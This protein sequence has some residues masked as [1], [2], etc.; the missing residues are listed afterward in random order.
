M[1]SS[2]LYELR[3]FDEILFGAAGHP[4]VPDYRS[5]AE[6]IQVIR[7]GFH[8]YVNLRPIR[9]LPGVSPR[10]GLADSGTVD[11]VIVRENTEGEFADIGGRLHQ[12]TD[13]ELVVQSAVF[14]RR[15][16]ERIARFAFELARGRR[17]LVSNV[18]KSN[19]LRHGLVYWDEV[20]ASVACAYPDVRSDRLYVDA[21]TVAILY[22]PTSFDVIVTTNLL[23]DI[24]SDL[25]SVVVGGLGVCASGNLDPARQYPSMFEPIHGS[26]PDIAGRGIANPIG[27]IRSAGMLLDHLGESGAANR[28]EAALTRVA[29]DGVLTADVGGRSST[30]EVGAAVV[31]AIA[32]GG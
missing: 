15:G 28:I 10:V 6:L 16:I 23:G 20:V 12:G 8:Q 9:T 13:H 29:G 32:D 18:T 25:A 21:A 5:S 2:A 17:S 24:V 4:D 14:T 11:F 7:R 30:A 31:R 27:A 1:P 3:G 26:A 19:A 22:R